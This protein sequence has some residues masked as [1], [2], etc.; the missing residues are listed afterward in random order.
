MCK[1]LVSRVDFL[2]YKVNRLGESRIIG[3]GK[4]YL[5]G[6]YKSTS[7]VNKNNDEDNTP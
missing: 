5:V 6:G 7:M 2:I 3:R 4:G 1:G